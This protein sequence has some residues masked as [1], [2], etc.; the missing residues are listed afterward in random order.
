MYSQ[1][2]LTAEEGT[3]TEL[4]SHGD[5]QINKSNNLRNVAISN[6]P[7]ARPNAGWDHVVVLESPIGKAALG[8]GSLGVEDFTISNATIS[9]LSF[10]VWKISGHLVL[11]LLG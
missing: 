4:D 9:C 5:K 11:H 2:L 10:S 3:S 6:H 8:K 1:T 7:F